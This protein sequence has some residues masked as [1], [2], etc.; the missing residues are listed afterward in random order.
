[1]LADAAEQITVELPGGEVEVEWRGSVH[2]GSPVYLTGPATKVFEGDI[3]A[4]VWT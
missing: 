2:D 1:V 3:G 4:E